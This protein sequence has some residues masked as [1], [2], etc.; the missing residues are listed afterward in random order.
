MIIL[1]ILQII[2]LIISVFALAKSASKR[3]R[4]MKCPLCHGE[5]QHASP[6]DRRCKKC[7]DKCYK[8]MNGCVYRDLG[9][10]EDSE[11]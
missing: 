7:C 9:E 2:I 6:C 8:K 10:R 1:L 11:G 3:S 4:E 5:M